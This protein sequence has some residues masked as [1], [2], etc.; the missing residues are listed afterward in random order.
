MYES[1]G[2]L[3]AT[4]GMLVFCHDSFTIRLKLR[5]SV[6]R[7]EIVDHKGEGGSVLIFV[8]GANAAAKSS[9]PDR[10]CYSP[11]RES[12]PVLP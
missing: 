2:C 5:V 10:V 11:Q 7:S 12:I 3:V 9:I 1:A 6:G 4:E 8:A